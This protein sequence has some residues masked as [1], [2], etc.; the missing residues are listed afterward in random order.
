MMSINTSPKLTIRE[1]SI[2]YLLVGE[3]ICMIQLLEG[4]LSTSITLKKDVRYPHRISK[5][6]AD[7]LLEGYR[8]ITLGRAIKLVKQHIY[9]DALY[10]DLKALLEE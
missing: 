10:N 6:E 9:P 7:S 8:S 1:E 2:L 5:I 4:A 3:A